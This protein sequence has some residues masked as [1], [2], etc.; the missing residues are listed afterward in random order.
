VEKLRRSSALFTSGGV[1][2]DWGRR[3]VGLDAIRRLSDQEFIGARGQ[4]TV[5]RVES[6]K[7]GIRLVADWKSNAYSGSS[8]FEFVLDGDVIKE[9]L[10]TE[11]TV[12]NSGSRC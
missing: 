7:K 4:L 12:R 11:A 5:N 1:A 3:F 10:I 6:T 9:M 8:G 2:N